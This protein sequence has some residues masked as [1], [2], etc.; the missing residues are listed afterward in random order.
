[1]TGGNNAL[2]RILIV[3]DDALLALD[4]AQHLERAGFAVAGRAASA[5]RAL[6]LLAQSGC[7][8]AILDVH[9]GKGQTSEA[10]AQELLSRGIPFVTVTA[11]SHEQRPPVYGS[12]P[13]LSKP[14]RLG[15]LL[16]ELRRCLGLGGS[17]R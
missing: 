4:L 2:S 17:S 7:D 14:L 15:D 3:E 6:S 13:V 5:A 9:L 12:S 10:V 8:A 11:Y 16:A 1:L